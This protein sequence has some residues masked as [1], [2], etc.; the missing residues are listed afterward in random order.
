[1]IQDTIMYMFTNHFSCILIYIF[2]NIGDI[3]KKILYGTTFK[4]LQIDF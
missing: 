1:M 4:R 2:C 3:I